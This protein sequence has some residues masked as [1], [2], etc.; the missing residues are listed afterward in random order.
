MTMGPSSPRRG[1][2]YRIP[3]PDG[4]DLDAFPID[5]YPKIFGDWIRATAA[6]TGTP[7]G[8]PGCLI[9]LYSAQLLAPAGQEISADQYM[10]PVGAWLRAA[11]TMPDCLER[12]R[13]FEVVTE[14]WTRLLQIIEAADG[15]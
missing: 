8:V 12:W 5:A 3:L 10:A 9:T 11:P 14:A 13:K 15:R 6:S 7:L 4:L 1:V 2:D